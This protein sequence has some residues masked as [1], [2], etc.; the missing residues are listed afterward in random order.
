MH[1]DAGPQEPAVVPLNEPAEGVPDVVETDADLARAVQA[2]S[3]GTGPTAVDAERASGYRYGQRTYLV[4]IRRAGAGTWLIDPIAQPDLSGVTEA[5]RG[6][7]WVLHAASQDLPGLAEQQMVPDAVFDTELAA[8]L[9]GMPRVG[10][11]AVVADTLGRGLAKEHSAVDWSTRP[12]PPDWLRYAALDV[13]LLVE[14]RAVLA[15]RLEEAGK[16]EWARQEFEAVR[17]APPPAP[18]VDPWRRTSGVHAVRST[19]GLAVVRSLW[20]ARDADARRRDISPGRVLPDAAIVA[21]ALA[22]PSTVADLVA[23]KQF[24]GKGTRRR[25]DQWFGAVDQALSLPERALP[26]LRG[27]GTPGPPPQRVWKDRDPAAAARLVAAKSVI[28]EAAEAY[29]VPPENL[30]QPD[31]LRRTCWSPPEQLTRTG[32]HDALLSGGARPWQAELLAGPLAE[33]LVTLG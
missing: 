3:G 26:S 13:E 18:R 4:Q 21:A 32:V 24:S 28:A 12:L 19:R 29:H 9:L 7:E 33:A 20:E 31:L 8:R 25:A 10:L 23:L 2:L 22:L 14:V 17:T 1:D 5:L 6:S 30:L 15:G 11:A 27:P 16:S